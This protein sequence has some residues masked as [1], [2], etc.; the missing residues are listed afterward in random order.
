MAGFRVKNG[1][2][3]MKDCPFC[4]EEVQA[5]AVVCDNC[6]SKLPVDQLM[7]KVRPAGRNAVIGL[8]FL[9][10]TFILAALQ[11]GARPTTQLGAIFPGLL[12]GLAGW[13]AIIFFII[14]IVQAILNRRKQI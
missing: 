13:I 14:A 7:K 6:G 9:I 4:F 3:V 5:G 2:C 1:V 10:L 11:S 8:V 12:T